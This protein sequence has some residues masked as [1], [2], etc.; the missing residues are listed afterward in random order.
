MNEK[1]EKLRYKRS[2]F[3]IRSYIFYFILIAFAITCCLLLFLSRLELDYGSVYE[4]GKLTAMNVLL[5]SLIITVLDGI[6]HKITVE[7]PMKHGDDGEPPGKCS[8]YSGLCGGRLWVII[9]QLLY[10]L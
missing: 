6:Y 7:Y 4:S 2:L 1:R 5:I 8:G 9:F 3:S 10:L